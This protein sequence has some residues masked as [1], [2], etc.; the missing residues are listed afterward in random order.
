[1]V[2]I[3]GRMVLVSAIQLRDDQWFLI[4]SHYHSQGVFIN[5]ALVEPFGLTLIE[6]AAHGLPMVATK[7]GGPVDIHKVCTLP[8]LSF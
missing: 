6:A 7:N 2:V 1:M 8:R 4:L 3:P 5:P